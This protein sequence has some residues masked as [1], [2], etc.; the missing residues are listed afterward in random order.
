MSPN[1]TERA[2]EFTPL[3]QGDIDLVAYAELMIN[4][5]YAQHYCELNETETAPLV[6]EAEAAIQDL[7]FTSANGVKF[8]NEK[9]CFPVAEGSFEDGM[10]AQD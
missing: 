1:W 9:C 4:I 5:G 2:M 8:V 6:V 10:G 3:G 7:D